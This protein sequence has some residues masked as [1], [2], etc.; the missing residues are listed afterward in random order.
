MRFLPTEAEVKLL[1][2]Y[3]RERQPLEELAAEDRF[4]LLFSKV[5]RLT[6]RMAG[7]AFLGNFQDNLQMLTPVQPPPLP[8]SSV[9]TRPPSTC[10]SPPLP[11]QPLPDFA[12]SWHGVPQPALHLAFQQLN[13]IIAASASVK[14]SQKLKQMLEVGRSCGWG[15]WRF[16]GPGAVQRGGRRVWPEFLPCIFWTDHTCAGELHEQQQAGS[17]VWLQAPEP[18][19]CKMGIG[20]TRG[21][22]A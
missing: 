5:E 22:E 7:M 6:Q 13:A 4:M 3:E 11:C 9:A 1:R 2:Q 16:P 17:C 19:S 21:Q 20:A 15:R 12:P 14:S 10:W 8:W 18:R